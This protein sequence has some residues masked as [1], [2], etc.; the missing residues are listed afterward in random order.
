M[1]PVCM[2]ITVFS[3]NK[4]YAA[5]NGHDFQTIFI[6]LPLTKSL[7]DDHSS[8]ERVSFLTIPRNCKNSVLDAHRSD[9]CS[10]CASCSSVR[11]RDRRRLTVPPFSVGDKDDSSSEVS[12]PTAIQNCIS[13]QEKTTKLVRWNEVSDADELIC[14][15]RRAVSSIHDPL[16]A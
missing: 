14:A 5:R 12:L 11:S 7:D 16:S 3:E 1:L 10:F 13:D 8:S 2:T 9:L 15:R 4:R 6:I